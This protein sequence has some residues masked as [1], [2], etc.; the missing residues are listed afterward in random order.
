[1]GLLNG[2]TALITGGARGQGRAHAV[3]SAQE[4]ADVI[5][6]DITEPIGSVDYPLATAEDMA[7][8]VRQV[9]ACDRR[10]LSFDAD[11]RNQSQLDAVVAAGIAEFGKI[12]I[13]IANA[14][15]WT[16]APF[17]EMSEETWIDMTDINLTGVWKS[18]KAVAPHMIER[19]TG[20]IVITSSVNGLEP[21]PAY[22]HYVAAK[23]GVIGLMKNIALELAPF[24]V[25][26]NSINPGAILTPMT[27]QQ[28][29]WDMF[30]GHEGGTYDDLLAGGYGFHALKGKTFLPPEAIAD[31][32]V[33][34]NSALAE[35]VTGVTIPVDA[36]HML[37]T[38]VNQDPVK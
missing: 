27:N 28:A 1:M 26:C 29:A 2:K 7:E 8:T 5:L 13:L 30:A 15:I 38:G 18:A 6:L 23:H 16:R 25:R 32:A 24:G 10:A 14:G 11:V 19:Q 37:L 12:D 17:W 22:A 35:N 21:G 4:G 3:R 20:S 34:L 33:Y 31:T 36:G 9:E